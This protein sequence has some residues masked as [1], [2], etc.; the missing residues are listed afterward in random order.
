M[1]A[2]KLERRPRDW[3]STPPSSAAA[4]K[5]L[6]VFANVTTAG[7]LF[8]QGGRQALAYSL[9]L[10][11]MPRS[12]TQGQSSP[13]S[14]PP[15]AFIL[16]DLC[17]SVTANTRSVRHVRPPM[18]PVWSKSNNGISATCRH[19]CRQ[20]NDLG[21]QNEA[22]R[23]RVRW[24]EGI[25]TAAD[26]ALANI[27]DIPTGQTVHGVSQSQHDASQT[28]ETEIQTIET[29][30]I[31]IGDDYGQHLAE[32]VPSLSQ[33]ITPLFLG[34]SQQPPGLPAQNTS[35]ASHGDDTIV[36]TPEW[37]PSAVSMALPPLEQAID[38]CKN[39]LNDHKQSHHIVDEEE[40]V[41]DLQKVYE[42]DGLTSRQ[43]S[44][45]RFRCFIILH[46]AQ[47]Q[48]YSAGAGHPEEQQAYKSTG[49]YRRLAL[50]DV[51]ETIGREDLE[52]VQ[53]LGLLALVSIQ[54]PEGPDFWH[55]IG[56]AARA[57]IAIGIHRK[58]SVYLPPLSNEYPDAQR[59][60]HHNDRR[61]NIFWA[62]YSLDR[63]ATF[64]LCRPPALR[65][66]DIDVAMLTLS[67]SPTISIQVPGPAVRAHSLEGRKLYGQ[68]HESLY[69]VHVNADKPAEEREA[70]ISNYTQQVHAWYASSPLRA[71]FV[72]LTEATVRRQIFTA[73]TTLVYCFREYQTRNDLTELPAHQVAKRIEECRELLN[74]FEPSSP[75]TL[76]YE[77]MFDSLA[78]PMSQEMW[79]RQQQ[80]QPQ[81]PQQS[82]V[83]GNFEAGQHSEGSPYG[84]TSL[85]TAADPA[86][87]ELQ[88]PVNGNNIDL[89]KHTSLSPTSLMRGFW[90]D[91]SIM[92]DIPWS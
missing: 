36:L 80:Q 79:H 45:N 30:R 41:Q 2:S 42:A 35:P 11:K 14:S 25:V 19:Y 64:T 89:F 74:Q 26:P 60:Q 9:F 40:L 65:D 50:R 18:C 51:G 15:A 8:A 59:L 7:Q 83:T 46:L 92:P 67:T 77:S 49:L 88:F 57:A 1:L 63:L 47:F 66:A 55:L 56:M 20:I 81:Q 87:N 53:A 3:I 52:C 21:A 62:I 6:A 90:A 31:V 44:R 37:S 43:L 32:T 16:A 84:T 24:L 38:M 39:F 91:T 76:L 61:K 71:A 13:R 5:L 22:L 54:E 4:P 12:E 27:A 75:R 29:S 34:L 33:S 69:G 23:R 82:H 70:I 73:C 48:P 78:S 58:D 85:S 17:H 68:I 28:H 10:Q 86:I 72:P